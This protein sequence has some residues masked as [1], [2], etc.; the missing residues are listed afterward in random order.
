MAHVPAQ[1]YVS[2]LH[3]AHSRSATPVH[4][5][6]LTVRFASTYAYDERLFKHL[7]VG[8]DGVA[9]LIPAMTKISLKS[10][11]DRCPYNELC[12]RLWLTSGPGT[13]PRNGSNSIHTWQ[14][15]GF[16]YSYL[17]VD[18]ACEGAVIN[19]GVNSQGHGFAANHSVGSTW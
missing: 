16:K 3:T 11:L 17:R 8:E 12:D 13:V 10:Q 1:R 5:P 2:W 7:Y 14:L 19:M 18:N 9:W 6:W 4:I 15:P